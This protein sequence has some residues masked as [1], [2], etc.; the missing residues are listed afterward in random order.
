MGIKKKLILLMPILL[1]GAL[2]VAL[3]IGGFSFYGAFST[4][5]GTQPS[6]I[7]C[8]GDFN[9]SSTGNFTND[10]SY[11]NPDGL[12]TMEFSCDDSDIES[13]DNKCNYETGKDV[14]FYIEK[15]GT[16]ELCSDNPQFELVSG[17]NNITI[18]AETHPNRCP[19]NGTIS[20][21]GILV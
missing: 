16:L 5:S 8:E 1:I 11:N 12:V 19:L 4:N 17:L 21:D 20:V 3:W 2:A 14:I 18:I 6:S 10:C 7:V 15:D 13:I 9:I